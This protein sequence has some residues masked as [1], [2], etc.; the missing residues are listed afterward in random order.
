MPRAL[1]HQCQKDASSAIRQTN[2][3]WLGGPDAKGAMEMLTELVIRPSDGPHRP[4]IDL[5]R[6]KRGREALFRARQ[7]TPLHFT[8]QEHNNMGE[9]RGCSMDLTGISGSRYSSLGYDVQDILTLGAYHP[10]VSP[11]LR[12]A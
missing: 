10:E 3:M 11:V 8:E 5:A 1:T 6:D 7:F 2:T 4:H 9:L 12:H